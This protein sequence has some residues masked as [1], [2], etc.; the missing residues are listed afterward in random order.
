VRDR[1]RSPEMSRA[2]TP[3]PA[4]VDSPEPVGAEG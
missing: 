3:V 1:R 2:V 4:D